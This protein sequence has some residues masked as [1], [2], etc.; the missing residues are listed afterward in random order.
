M[1]DLGSAV[2]ESKKMLNAV[3]CGTGKSRLDAQT[4][5]ARIL[6][7]GKKIA[8]K[9]S[10]NMSQDSGND[11]HA[12]S[13]EPSYKI[14]R[15]DLATEVSQHYICSSDDGIMAPLQKSFS[16]PKALSL[17][18]SET[19]TCDLLT[20]FGFDVYNQEL[21]KGSEMDESTINREEKVGSDES[22]ADASHDKSPLVAEDSSKSASA[23][24]N[25][26]T[27]TE[28]WVPVQLTDIQLEQYCSTIITNSGL[29]CSSS[30]KGSLDPLQDVLGALRKCCDHPYVLDSKLQ[31]FCKDRCPLV[32]YL[33][34]GIQASGKLQLLSKFLPEIR[35]QGLRVLIVYKTTSSSVKNGLGIG[36]IL[37]DFICQSFGQESYVHIYTQHYVPPKEK[38]AAVDLFNDKTSGRFVVLTEYSSPP[39]SIRLTSVDVVILFNSDMNPINDIRALQKMSLHTDNDH[40]RVLR[41]YSC[42]TL[43]EK[44]LCMARDGSAVQSIRQFISTRTCQKLLT[45]GATCLF[46]KLDVIHASNTSESNKSLEDEFFCSVLHELSIVLSSNVDCTSISCSVISKVNEVGEGCYGNIELHGELQVQ[47]LNNVVPHVIWSSI[48]HGRIPH[49][50][51][52][53]NK[54]ECMKRW[55]SFWERPPVLYK[56]IFR[57]TGLLHEEIPSWHRGTNHYAKRSKRV[58]GG[59]LGFQQRLEG[60]KKLWYNDISEN[61]KKVDEPLKKRRLEK[62]NVEELEH[63]QTIYDSQETAENMHHLEKELISEICGG[64]YKKLCMFK[65]LDDEI[66]FGGLC[67]DMDKCWEDLYTVHTERNNDEEIDAPSNLIDSRNLNTSESTIDTLEQPIQEFSPGEGLNIADAN[68]LSHDDSRN[69]NKS[70]SAIET[71]EPIQELCLGEELDTEIGNNLSREVESSSNRIALDDDLDIFDEWFPPNEMIVAIGSDSENIYVRPVPVPV[72]ELSDPIPPEDNLIASDCASSPSESEIGASILTKDQNHAPQ[73]AISCSSS[74]TENQGPINH[75]QSSEELAI[76]SDDTL[77]DFPETLYEETLH[78][79]EK[80]PQRQCID[81]SHQS[82][83]EQLPPTQLPCS[84]IRVTDESLPSTSCEIVGNGTYSKPLQSSTGASLRPDIYDNHLMMHPTVSG[85]EENGQPPLSDTNGNYYLNSSMNSNVRDNSHQPARLDPLQAELEKIQNAGNVEIKKHEDMVLQLKASRDKEIAQ[86]CQK[87]ALLYQNVQKDFTQKKEE[88]NIC[89]EKTKAHKSLA[90]AWKLATDENIPIFHPASLVQSTAIQ[91]NIQ[92]PSPLPVNRF[93][94]CVSN[95]TLLPPYPPPYQNLCN[96]QAGCGP[97]VPIPYLYPSFPARTNQLHR[98]PLSRLSQHPLNFSSS[99]FSAAAYS[100]L[101]SSVEYLAHYNIPI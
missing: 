33:S 75:M 64:S 71:L 15:V 60:I 14:Q 96:P 57:E 23:D 100:Q 63:L 10:N 73:N 69:H 17:F 42:C 62:Q 45:W 5:R 53:P 97:Y 61:I 30:K 27:F 24:S 47:S 21:Q 54:P 6:S 101:Y 41:L 9:R 91:T 51:F 58:P 77:Q 2:P 25:N 46:D 83:L 76:L 80:I 39:V 56:G 7:L 11:L 81:Q 28:Y 59:K 82:P 8:K 1:E 50:R 72:D 48:L 52:L 35:K 78:D 85:T 66:Q 3:S 84:D 92:S 86:I 74:V 34:I 90:D 26:L 12:M 89:Y 37:D 93:S 43:E 65:K 79:N 87:Y 32:D 20:Y 70:E 16:I 36:D 49:W 40:L 55:I 19:Y 94:D 29:L 95:Q 99:G 13:C 38:Q 18:F 22:S 4:Y 67:N 98:Y 31:N 68:S 44:A 88:L